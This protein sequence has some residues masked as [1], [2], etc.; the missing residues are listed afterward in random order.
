M[1]LKSYKYTYIKIYAMLRTY[2][3]IYMCPCFAEL[4]YLQAF[5]GQAPWMDRPVAI[6]SASGVFSGLLFQLARDLTRDTPLEPVV[7]YLNCPVFE[8]SGNFSWLVFGAGIAV[9]L[10]IGPAVDLAWLLRQKWR[11]WIWNCFS[12]ELPSRSL[13]KVLA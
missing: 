1:I 2:I 6:G 11:R 9:G 4:K 7:P 13:H 8:N 10:C 12:A 5:W 3:Y